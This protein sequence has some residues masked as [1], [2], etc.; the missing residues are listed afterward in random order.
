MHG[1]RPQTTTVS[2]MV[3]SMNVRQTVEKTLSQS[4][5]RGDPA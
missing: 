5:C 3:A 1:M 4:V 2:A